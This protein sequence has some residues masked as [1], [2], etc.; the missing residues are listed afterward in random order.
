MLFYTFNGSRNRR[1]SD[2]RADGDG[3]C[4]SFSICQ[5]HIIY[6]AYEARTG[7][8]TI[9][10]PI[11]VPMGMGMGMGM[12]ARTIRAHYFNPSYKPSGTKSLEAFFH[13]SAMYPHKRH[14][15]ISISL[16]ALPIS[17]PG[18]FP[19]RPD[20]GTGIE[21]VAA[22]L[23]LPVLSHDNQFLS[24]VFSRFVRKWGRV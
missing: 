15:H 16:L 22:G 7:T 1:C 19:V 10:V 11:G 21:I 5:T 14:I 2:R 18:L 12:D 13:T 24:P 23:F 17:I 9:G 4:C 8:G 20:V 3:G 6:I